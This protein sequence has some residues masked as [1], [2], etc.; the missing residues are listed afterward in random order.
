M[1]ADDRAV[2][3]EIH[4]LE[5]RL[6]ELENEIHRLECRNEE[7]ENENNSLRDELFHSNNRICDLVEREAYRDELVIRRGW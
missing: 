3:D 6:E 1:E 4:R 5:R 7:L 2:A